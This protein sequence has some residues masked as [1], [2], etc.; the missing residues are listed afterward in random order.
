MAVRYG[1]CKFRRWAGATP[2]CC[3]RT[4]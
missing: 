2:S 3:R 4:R 1:Q